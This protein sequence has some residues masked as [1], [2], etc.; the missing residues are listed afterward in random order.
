MTRNI[1]A[2]A[3]A[4]VADAIRRKVVYV[5]LVFAAVLALMIPQLPTY[6]AGVV[7]GVF[8]EVSLALVF[9]VGLVLTLSLSAN[10]V[11]AE[12]ERRTVYNVLAKR[13]TRWEYLVGT[14]LGIIAVVGF[15]VVAF[16]LVTQAVALLRYGQPMWRLWEGSLGIW[17]EMA[18]LAAFAVAVSAVTGPVVVVTASLTFLFFAHAR[19][20]F[21]GETPSGVLALAYPSFD[22]FNVINP[23]SHGTGV[24]VAYV[25]AMLA[26]FVGWSA[27]LLLAAAGLFSRRDL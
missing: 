27:L 5:V 18:T 1:G 23:V 3:S 26:V 12:V 20:T 11:P 8:R 16:T 4:V 24:T 14:W 10:R 21:L 19:S 22:T 13:V 17:L 25:G 6:G 7:E 9:V 2:I 15:A